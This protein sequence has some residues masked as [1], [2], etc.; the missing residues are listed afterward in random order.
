MWLSQRLTFQLNRNSKSSDPFWIHKR[1][2]PARPLWVMPP[3]QKM[4]WRP[5]LWA[6]KMTTSL[7][8]THSFQVIIRPGFYHFLHTYLMALLMPQITNPIHFLCPFYRIHVSHISLGLWDQK[9]WFPQYHP[10]W[11]PCH[12]GREIACT[13][14]HSETIDIL[15]REKS[16]RY[17]EGE[18]LGW[19]GFLVA[20]G[21]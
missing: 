20:L 8:T 13:T 17:R 21:L 19:M 4:I 16:G 15:V 14:W 5:Q 12:L 9:S 18:T 7:M 6:K 1:D 3:P 10:K 11:A 2:G